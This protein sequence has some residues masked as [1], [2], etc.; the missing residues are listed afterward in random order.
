MLWTLHNI[1]GSLNA[2]TIAMKYTFF[3]GTRSLSRSHRFLDLL[4]RSPQSWTKSQY[5]QKTAARTEDAPA[6]TLSLGFNV[7]FFGMIRCDVGSIFISL[8]KPYAVLKQT[9][10]IVNKYL[11]PL[12]PWSR[13]LSSI[14]RRMHCTNWTTEILSSNC[15]RNVSFTETFLYLK[16]AGKIWDYSNNVIEISEDIW[17]SACAFS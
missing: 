6:N 14:I 1:E 2:L 16:E 15:S 4:F 8:S 9:A 12:Y 7:G 10:I 11:T 13:L 3:C 5:V 17:L